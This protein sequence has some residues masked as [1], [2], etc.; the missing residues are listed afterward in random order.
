MPSESSCNQ[1]QQLLDQLTTQ[2]SITETVWY[3]QSI[4]SPIDE[5]TSIEY[6]ECKHEYMYMCATL[7]VGTCTCMLPYS[8][9]LISLLSLEHEQRTHRNSLRLVGIKIERQETPNY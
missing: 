2:V 8:D 5:H 4:R 1:I 7:W 3:W 6:V 9:Q